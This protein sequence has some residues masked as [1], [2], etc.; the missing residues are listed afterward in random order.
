M[1]HLEKRVEDHYTTTGLLARIDAALAEM[2]VSG[3]DPDSLKPIDEFHTGGLEA[4]EALLTQLEITPQTRVL[5]IGAG[6]GGTARHIVHRYGAHVTGVD[7]THSFVDVAKALN[8]R[9]RYSAAI[10]MIQG[11]ALDLPV[12]GGSFDLA[13]MLHVGMNIEDKPRLMAEVARVLRPGG[14]FALFDVMRDGADNNLVFPLPWSEAAGTSFVDHPL[15]YRTA[16]EGA[17][18]EHV[19]QRGRRD[20]T[21]HYFARVF[22]AMEQNGPAPLGIHLLMRETAREKLQ[23]YVANVEAH[24]IAP[25]EM[26]FRKPG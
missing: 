24:R 20:F 8:E 4:T 14:T 1:E 2:G 11:S 22:E 13:V 10:T 6:L 23:N 5:D 17:G 25:V 9:V 21:L 7:L 15:A 12:A 3:G 19:A 18:L 16:G 26:I